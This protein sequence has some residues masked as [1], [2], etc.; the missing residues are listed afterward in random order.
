MDAAI[1]S[2]EDNADDV[3]SQTRRAHS[4]TGFAAKGLA[5]AAAIDAAELTW[6]GRRSN[7]ISEPWWVVQGG[8][9]AAN[10]RL[11]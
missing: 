6:T 7:A 4:L 5:P 1:V 2:P 3:R 10:C 9:S 11:Y 8:A